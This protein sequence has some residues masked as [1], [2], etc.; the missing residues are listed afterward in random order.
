LRFDLLGQQTAKGAPRQPPLESSYPISVSDDSSLSTSSKG[1]ELLV[2]EIYQQMLAQDKAGNVVV[3]HDVQ[4]QGRATSHQLDVYWE[5]RLGGVLHKVAVQAKRWKNPIRKGEV[6]T[7]KGVLDDLPGTIGIMVS[8][9]RFQKGAVEV[10]EAAGIMLCSLQ[11]ITKQP[12]SFYAGETAQIIMKG[13][14]QAPDGSFLG[15]LADVSQKIPSVSDVSLKADRDWHQAN[16][17]LP[18]W[19]SSIKPSLPDY[20]YDGDGEKLISLREILGGFYA[21]MHR[22]GQMSA[23]K[24]HTFENPTF[25]KLHDPPLTIKEESLSARIVF[26]PK[27][28]QVVFKAPNVAEFILK[29]LLSGAEHHIVTK[30]PHPGS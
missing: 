20:F 30:T 10:A 1:Y 21:E 2:R 18:D 28:T 7:F 12:V 23:L 19:V 9:S 14:L 24:T 5:L 13:M 3:E 17:P 25:F 16:N 29:N 6:L 4:K 8:S 15:M 27:L 22:E 11:E 26:T